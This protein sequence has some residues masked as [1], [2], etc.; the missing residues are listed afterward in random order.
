MVEF[1]IGATVLVLLFTGIFQYGYTFYVYNCLQNA[2]RAGARYASRETYDSASSTPSSNFASSVK[3]M[4]IYGDPNATS[5]ATVV[6]G[7]TNANVGLTVTFTSGVPRKMT[8]AIT[9]YTLNAVL[10]TFTLT[11]KPQATM[12]FVGIWAP[13]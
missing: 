12:P 4:V 6:P 9:G 8:V 13:A 5:G 10:K 1:A 7:L 11:N 3:N 2:V